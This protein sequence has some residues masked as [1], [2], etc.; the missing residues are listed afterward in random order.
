MPN[1]FD[2]QVNKKAFQINMD[3]KIYGTFAEIGAGQEVARKFFQVGGAA[4]TVAKTMSAYDMTFSDAI[5]GASGRYVSRQRLWTML[6]HEFELLLERLDETVGAERTFFVFANTVAARSFRR[7]D[8]SHGWLGVRFQTAPRSPVHE[9]I[10]H[11]RMLDPENLQQQEALGIIGVNLIY[12]AFFL[13]KRPEA[14]IGSLLDDLSPGRMEVDMIKFSGPDFEKLDQRLMALQLVTQGLS[15]SA[16][17]R[18]D[19]E[20]VQPAEVFYKKPLLV[21]R[22]SFRPVTLVT[23]DMLDCAREMFLGEEPNKDE[24]PEVLMEMTL[25]NLLRDGELDLLDFLDRVDILSALGRTVLISNYGEYYHLVNYLTRYTDKMIGLPLGIPA[26]RE[27]F[28]EKYYTNLEG[29]ILEGLGRLFKTGVKLYVYPK[30]EENGHL[31]T[32]ENFQV[33]PNLKH[34]YAHLLENGF[35]ES[36]RGY[37]S[38]YF[39]IYSPNV[40]QKI[41]DRDA[42]WKTMVPDEVAKVIEERQLFVAH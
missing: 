30:Q 19:G 34:L 18:A 35:I 39:D 36:M 7:H 5:Y 22:G 41:R 25:Q 29:G 6:D 17:F 2:R 16:L 21:E 3:P 14:L 8:E 13:A 11:V 15:K 31:T 26:M 23:N 37:H 24:E 27:I 4:G 32:A 40:L 20:V 42:S 38:D 28:D 33:A 10:I 9:I 12:G 1:E